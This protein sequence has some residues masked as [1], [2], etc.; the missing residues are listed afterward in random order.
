M[1]DAKSWATIAV[2][3]LDSLLEGC[4]VVDFD[5][6]YRF[7]NEAALRQSKLTMDELLGRRM[8]EC[9][10]GIEQTPMFR[11]LRSCMVERTYQ[12]MDNEF[13]F[14]DGS[15]GWFDLRF[16]PVP[17]GVCILSLDVTEAKRSAANL[18]VVQ[19]QLRHAQKMEAIGRLAGGVAHDFNNIL[20]VIMTYGVLL[21]GALPQNSPFID[22]VDEMTKAAERA[23]RLTE[24]LL[25]FS[26][27]QVI[28][29]RVLDLSDLV[30]GLAPMTQK[31]LGEDVVVRTSSDPGPAPIRADPSQ[32]EQVIINLVVNARD[33]MPDG[34]TLDVE[35]ERVKLS[36]RPDAQHD[37]AELGLPP[38][39]YV[40]LSVK[41]S[42]MG[43]DA[44]TREHIFEPFFS[45]KRPQGGTGLGLS[46]VY[47]IVKQYGGAI[48]VSSEVGRGT[49]F[50]VHLPEATEPLSR[51]S[52]PPAAGQLHGT[53][54]ILLAEDDEQ[55]RR[56]TQMM[57]EDH[58]YL[59]LAAKNGRLALE[60][61]E[62]YAGK[63]DLLLTDVV[64]PGMNGRQLATE[65]AVARPELRVIYMTG[66]TEDS[67]LHRGVQSSTV[68][69]VQKPFTPD[70]LLT[71]IR[72]VLIGC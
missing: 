19:D 29:P 37:G 54:T 21:R 9:F 46:T 30:R 23:A 67:I 28:R 40:H 2:D 63:I 11:K 43:M 61:S 4:Q 64:M 31:L 71:R 34:G 44:A 69:L 35:I 52:V 3:V 47:G 66:Y 18:A 10:P 62:R 14:P 58:G 48:T 24:Q 8:E 41:D 38:G 27:R 57:L 65:L 59:V 39:A 49:R 20:S 15:L 13:R 16:L 1:G 56:V 7:L 42:G 25:T 53:E 55:L 70:R 36:A 72:Q 45:T 32:L 26:R 5:Y 51:P 50:D 17:E 12:R 6:R 68:V 60:T 33:A 22:D